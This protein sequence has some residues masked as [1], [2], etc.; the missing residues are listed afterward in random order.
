[1]IGLI[2]SLCASSRSDHYFNGGN[3]DAIV[4]KPLYGSGQCVALVQH[5]TNVGRTGLWREGTKITQSRYPRKG[6]AI[7]TFFGG[8]YPSKPSGNHAAFFH[9]MT[10]S[11]M[12]VV[13][14]WSSSGGVQKRTIRFTGKGGVNDASIYSTIA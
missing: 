11:G 2:L 3:L 7:A 14:Q 10:N 5:F 13:D 8:V 1:M 6:A 12:V 4:G 9:S